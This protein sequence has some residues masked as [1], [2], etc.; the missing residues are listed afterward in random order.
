M[1]CVVISMSMSVCAFAIDNSAWVTRDVVL[2]EAEFNTSALELGSG[3][4][5]AYVVANIS[6]LLNFDRLENIAARRNN[7]FN[8][9]VSA[10]KR[11][12]DFNGYMYY[13]V[14]FSPVGYAIYDDTMSNLLVFNYKA[15]SPYLN[16]NDGLIFAGASQYYI[17]SSYEIAESTKSVEVG[18]MVIHAVTG[19]E[20]Q[21]DVDNLEKLQ[22]QSEAI[23]DAVISSRNE[24]SLTN[25]EIA[26]SVA[27]SA[28]DAAYLSQYNVIINADTTGFNTSSNCGYVAAAL[29]VWYHYKVLGW[30]DF[31]PDGELTLDLVDDIQNGRLNG[32]YGPDVQSALSD[33]SYNH[34]AVEPG[35]WQE[36]LPGM[37]NLLPTASSILDLIDEDRPVILL[38]KIYDP[39]NPTEKTDHAIT[40]HGVEKYQDSIFDTDW[41]YYA[42]YGWNSDYNDEYVSDDVIIKGCAVYY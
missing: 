18:D 42:H 37:I 39:T 1:L 34:G 16:Y 14:E 36:T 15:S 8:S 20:L 6:E 27:S 40:I 23:S 13:V 32:T 41:Y 21:I 2:N 19:E 30:D 12:Y 22:T 25:T 38:G 31:V 10:V 9:V 29:V 17:N 3:L 4:D 11:A 7:N 28:T 35:G 24:K 5:Y 26:R 33:W